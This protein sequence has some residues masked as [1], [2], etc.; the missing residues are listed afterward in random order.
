VKTPASGSW[1]CGWGQILT[2][3]KNFPTYC[4]PDS[5]MFRLPSKLYV[6]PKRW[7]RSYKTSTGCTLVHGTMNGISSESRSQTALRE[8]HQTLRSRFPPLRLVSGSPL[9]T[10]PLGPKLSQTTPTESLALYGPRGTLRTT[11]GAVRLLG[12]SRL[13]I[14]CVKDGPAIVLQG[15]HAKEIRSPIDD[16]DFG[17]FRGCDCR[18]H[19]VEEIRGGVR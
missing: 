2:A 13:V 8:N 5:T 19:M 18:E 17:K 12:L 16:R 11:H 15:F 3:R 14:S 7:R 6:A 10:P 4:P 1:V 9:S